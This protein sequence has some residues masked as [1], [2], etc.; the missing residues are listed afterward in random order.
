MYPEI[1]SSIYQ[2]MTHLFI[3]HLIYPIICLFLH[4][5]INLSTGKWIQTLE[6]EIQ[7]LFNY[8]L[9][10]L[11]LTIYLIRFDSWLKLRHSKALKIEPTATMSGE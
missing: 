7:K 1:Y 3:N 8:F 2:I 10:N 5:P 9:S 11:Y 4:P 6:G